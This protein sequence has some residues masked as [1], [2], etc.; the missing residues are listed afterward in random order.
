MY[1][2]KT[3]RWLPHG[4]HDR[5]LKLVNALAFFGAWLEG[6]QHS[7]VTGAIEML[8]SATS[9]FSSRLKARVGPVLLTLFSEHLDVRV[10]TPVCEKL[11]EYLTTFAHEEF[12]AALR[13]RWSQWRP[14]LK[15]FFQNSTAPA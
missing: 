14:D 9:G 2:D 4:S 15:Q 8:A 3:T 6:D 13:D 11:N 5:V 1:S 12:Q 10:P 7:Q